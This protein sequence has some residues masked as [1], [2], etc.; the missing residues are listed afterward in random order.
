MN[1]K[2]IWSR[3]WK[4]IFFSVYWKEIHNLNIWYT[5]KQ[6][7][8]RW[9]SGRFAAWNGRLCILPSNSWWFLTFLCPINLCQFYEHYWL[10]CLFWIFG[11]C[12]DENNAIKTSKSEETNIWLKVANCRRYLKLKGTS[13]YGKFGSCHAYE[14]MNIWWNPNQN[15]E[16]ETLIKFAENSCFFFFV[17]LR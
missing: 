13:Y 10:I 11:M 6:A 14:P 7:N 3:I 2:F 5:K 8:T 17:D 9:L 15:K 4:P 1:Q 16:P 12:E